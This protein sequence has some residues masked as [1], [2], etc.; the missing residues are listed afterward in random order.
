MQPYGSPKYRRQSKLMR[1]LKNRTYTIIFSV[2]TV[3]LLYF[4]LSTKGFVS[5]ITLEREL[6][7]K[8][9]RVISLEREIQNL[10]R[11]RDLLR[12]DDATIEQVAREVHGMIKSGEIVYRVIPAGKK[13]HK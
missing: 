3:M 7:K 11:E 2:A 5:R 13:K 10:T 4:A 12:D 8:Q 1:L 9:E 6:A